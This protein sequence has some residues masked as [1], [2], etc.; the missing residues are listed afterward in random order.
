MSWEVQE[1]NI[2]SNEI[3]GVLEEEDEGQNDKSSFSKSEELKNN[4]KDLVEMHLWNI[5]GTEVKS[6]KKGRLLTYSQKQLENITIGR[7]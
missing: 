6:G 3:N 1:N 4:I 7:I 5:K 2:S